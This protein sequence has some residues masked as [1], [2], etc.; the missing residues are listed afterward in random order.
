M[1]RY[2]SIVFLLAALFLA[3]VHARTEKNEP[4]EPV[5]E[6][7]AENLEKLASRIPSGK[8]HVFVQ[9]PFVVIGDEAQNV[10]EKRARGT[11]GW[12]VRL[13]KKAYFEKD[14]D[15]I[16]HIWLFRD[17]ESYLKNAKELFG[18]EPGTPFGYYSESDKALVMNIATGGGTLVHEIVHPFVRANFARCPTWFNEGLGSLYEQCGEREG[19]IVGYTNWRLAGLQEAIE[20]D[21]LPSFEELTSTT[22]WQF[23]HRD[24]GTNYA[25]ARY[26]CYY[27]QEKGL[28]R[29]YYRQFR[30][31]H[32]DDPTGL[33]TL[34]SVL[35]TEDMQAFKREWEKWVLGL[36]FP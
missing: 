12:A 11:V 31:S 7:L 30:A 23:Y 5:G 29:S 34:K 2:L 6:E 8:F 26:L 21:A 28:L 10:V 20:E 27:L 36:S 35:G 9:Q 33:E 32:E 15:E 19:K 1:T 14:P 13:L 24:P 22:E 25:Q 16:I 17:K 4:P 3:V 18:D